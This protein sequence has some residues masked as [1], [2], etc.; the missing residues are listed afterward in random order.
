MDPYWVTL[1]IFIASFFIFF[2]FLLAPFLTMHQ[3]ARRTLLY[4][5]LFCFAYWN[6]VFWGFFLLHSIFES[7]AVPRGS[8]PEGSVFM[9]YFYITPVFAVFI[10]IELLIMRRNAKREK[11]ALA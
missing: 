10:I 6:L 1:I 2:S 3:R 8:D 5:Q 9:F 11:K 4:I 7:L